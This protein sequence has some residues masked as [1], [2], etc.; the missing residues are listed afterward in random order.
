MRKSI[1]ASLLLLCYFFYGYTSIEN[2]KNLVVNSY[3]IDATNGNDNNPGNSPSL[4]W[5]TLSKVNSFNFASG[6]VILLKRGET[7]L[8]PFAPSVSNISVGSYG[9]GANPII[10]GATLL[11]TWTNLGGGIYETALALEPKV[12]TIGAKQF[13]PGRYPN[14][15]WLN[16]D[17]TNGN[18]ITS[19]GLLGQT[20]MVGAKV[21]IRKN[22]FIIEKETVTS[23][24]GNTINF[25]PIVYSAEKDYGFFITNKLSTLDQY[26]EWYYDAVAHKLKVFFGANSPTTV[27]VSSVPEVVSLL[28]KTNIKFDGIE[29][30]HANTDMVVVQNTD[31]ISFIN[32]Q[33]H[34]SGITAIIAGDAFNKHLSITNCSFSNINSD[35]IKMYGTDNTGLLIQNNTFNR[36]GIFPGEGGTNEYRAISL[37]GNA[38]FGAIISNNIIDS[39]G[40]CGINGGSTNSLIKNNIITNFCFLMDDG[41]GIYTQ[42]GTGTGKR[43]TGN[44]ISRG[45]LGAEAGTPYPANENQAMGIYSDAINAFTEIDNNSISNCNYGIYIDD[46]HDMNIH[47]NNLFDNGTGMEIDYLGHE[48]IYNLQV[49]NNTITNKD[50]SSHLFVAQRMDN[51]GAAISTWGIIDSNYYARPLLDTKVIYSWSGSG[52]G[53]EYTLPE[54][55]PVYGFD[56]HSH[57]SPKSVSAASQIRYET[58]PTNSPKLVSLGA[59]YLGVDSIA[60]TSTITLAPWTSK[61][62]LYFS[63]ALAITNDPRIIYVSPIKETKIWEYNKVIT[64][65]IVSTRAEPVKIEVFDNIGRLLYKRDDRVILGQ[66][67]FTIPVQVTGIVIFRLSGDG[68]NVVKK[69]FIR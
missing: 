28:G 54:W 44:F 55:R 39:V 47:H 53:V 36:M 63:G 30:T 64:A 45:G 57:K 49:K 8:A 40:Y 37:E 15:G 56:A 23:Q 6:D 52:N 7:F 10:S 32:C 5:K 46:S 21:V 18:S 2:R 24:S 13:A 48:P 58:N 59:T 19:T 20:G 42:E 22:R 35:G 50:V 60:Y 31:G 61:T 68:I 14:S 62:L 69:L 17:A 27:A 1:Y 11:S 9:T 33:F 16:I 66:K 65:Q 4:P 3:Y 51:T 25:N 29:F 41:G 34:F 12:V 26:G 67:I 38:S 43:I